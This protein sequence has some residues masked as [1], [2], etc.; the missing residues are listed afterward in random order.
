ML[1]G[2]VDGKFNLRTIA[3]TKLGTM[4]LDILMIIRKS[5]LERNVYLVI[6]FLD[7]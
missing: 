3:I 6:P 2:E 4:H 1:N 7:Q 5:R